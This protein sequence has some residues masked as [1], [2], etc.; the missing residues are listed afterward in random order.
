VRITNFQFEP[1]ELTIDA[2]TTVEWIDQTGRHTVSADDESFKS[3]VLT[4]GGVFEH[5]FDAPG[6]Y[7]YY[8]EF[9]GDKHG[10]EMAGVITVKT[11]DSER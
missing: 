3:E 1:R 7:P 5:R 11:P 6:L 8:C 2:G 9:H 4:A 10:K